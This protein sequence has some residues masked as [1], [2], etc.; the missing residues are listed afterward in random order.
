[1]P[2][3]SSVKGTRDNWQT[4]GN[5]SGWWGPITKR[6]CPFYQQTSLCFPLVQIKTQSQTFQLNFQKC[7][8]KGPESASVMWTCPEGSNI[9]PALTLIENRLGK[10][11]IFS[12][13]RQC[14]GSEKLIKSSYILGLVKQSKTQVNSW[15]NSGGKIIRPCR[16]TLLRVLFSLSL[17]EERS[18][19]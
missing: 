16:V 4:T 19:G 8:K 12:G 1:M 3:L 9:A 2:W 14:F 18:E 6:E 10:L 5:C 13:W 15:N 7:P 11:S 17:T